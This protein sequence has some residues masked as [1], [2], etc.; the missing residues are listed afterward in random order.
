MAIKESKNEPGRP[1]AI[2]CFAGC[3]GMSQG[4]RQA[5]IKVVGAIEIDADAVRV[6]TLNHPTVHTWSQ[7]IRTV[8]AEAILT[9]LG[10][11]TGELDLLGGWPTVPRVFNAANVQWWAASAGQPEQL[12]L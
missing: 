2:D 6:Y 12:D 3:G 10:I 8:T 5:G 1:I 9:Q 4:F 11:K 7:D